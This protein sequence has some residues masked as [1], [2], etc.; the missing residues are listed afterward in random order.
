M[1][2][3]N[4]AKDFV[5]AMYL[6]PNGVQRRNM[7]MDGFTEVS[8]NMGITCAGEEEL[9]IVFSPRSS[10]ASLQENMKERFRTLAESF[11]FAA[12]YSGEYPGWSYKEDSRI[13]EVFKES[14]RSL[15]GSEIK[16]EA[17]HAGLECGILSSKIEGLDCVSIGPNMKDIHTTEEKLSISSTERIW[18]YVLAV[19]AEKDRDHN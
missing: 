15:F 1:V 14:Y 19:L 17:I 10:V 16:I 4:A 2:P 7:H 9:S 13:R 6:A 11:G 18:K 3:K 8:C 5:N 12:E